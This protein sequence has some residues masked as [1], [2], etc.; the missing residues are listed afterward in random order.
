MEGGDDEGDAVGNAFGAG[1]RISPGSSASVA[2]R[3]GGGRATRG[4]GGGKQSGALGFKFELRIDKDRKPEG[5]AA[6]DFFPTILM[7]NYSQPIHLKQALQSSAWRDLGMQNYFEGVEVEEGKQMIIIP[8]MP[9]MLNDYILPLLQSPLEL[10]SSASGIV[11]R[12]TFA[13][14]DLPAESRVPRELS[15]GVEG[16]KDEDDNDGIARSTGRWDR[17]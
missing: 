2:G 12:R 4:A 8:I 1:I 15:V 17:R 6:W 10:L 3:G 5:R 9:R 11:D 7:S 16:H 14:G 13:V